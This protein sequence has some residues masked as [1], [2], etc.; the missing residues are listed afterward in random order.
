[1]LIESILGMA[2]G[3]IG[4]VVGGIFKFKTAK[5]QKEIQAAQNTHALA[6]VK[7]ESDAMI[8]EAKANI[9]ITRA[10]VEGAI[11]LEDARAFVSAQKEGNKQMFSHKWIDMLM[12]VQGKWQLITLPIA[13]LLSVMFAFTDFI[14]G[15][16]R[17]ALTIYL[18]GVT[19]WITMMAWDIMQK[20]G[21]ELSAT[22]ALTTFGEVTGV[23]TYLTISAVTFWF[24]DRSMNKFL[25][26]LKGKDD[27]RIDNE[28]RI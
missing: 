18:C 12:N 15:L 22:Q 26:E 16:I 4:N 2:T 24:G 21:I 5:L 10:Q 19:T 14:R 27:T 20:Y 8:A 9:A 11:D 7:A 6:M 1:M 3:L 17:P 23:V 13:M 28:I 25:T